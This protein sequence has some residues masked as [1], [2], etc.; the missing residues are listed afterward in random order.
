MEASRRATP[1]GEGG[2][3]EAEVATRRNL[4]LL[5][6]LRRTL[7]PPPSSLRPEDGVEVEE[8]GVRRTWRLRGA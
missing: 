6:R 1:R 3:T 2:A 5:V 8:G 7:R 4:Q